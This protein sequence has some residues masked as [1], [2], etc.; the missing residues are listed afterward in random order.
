ME[1]YWGSSVV[2]LPQ[3][4]HSYRSAAGSDLTIGSCYRSRQAE[5]D[6]ARPERYI[7]HMP[8]WR[9]A[10]MRWVRMYR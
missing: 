1:T 6:A 10:T 4:A 5:E 9:A 7:P 2:S 8:R 3:N